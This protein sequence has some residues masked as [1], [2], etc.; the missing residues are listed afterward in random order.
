[1]VH[2]QGLRGKAE[3][4]KGP[5]F[6]YLGASNAIDGDPGRLNPCTAMSIPGGYGGVWWKV[7]MERTFN[8]AEIKIYFQPASKQFSIRYFK[9][10]SN[11]KQEIFLSP[12]F[13]NV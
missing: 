9:V 3:M 1:L 12:L 2:D 4:S 8:I 11:G 7:W 13:I 6:D 10:A 5:L